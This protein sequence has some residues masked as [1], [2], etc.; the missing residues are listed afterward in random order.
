MLCAAP[1]HCR[2]GECAR[3]S[4]WGGG[5]CHRHHHPPAR[6]RSGALGELR[7]VPRG[8]WGV[9]PLN[10]S[11]ALSSATYTPR[12]RYAA[13]RTAPSTASG[14]ASHS[15]GTDA[16]RRAVAI[17][18]LLLAWSP[19]RAPSSLELN[20]PIRSASTAPHR[21]SAKSEGWR[22]TPR[23]RRRRRCEAY[24]YCTRTRLRGRGRDLAGAKRTWL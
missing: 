2:Q 24:M 23:R 21:C 7:N 16:T 19:R 18:T 20:D 3:L 13:H 4:M 6:D 15:G 14:T 11:K 1:S 22:L 10:F 17:G 9:A 12:E 5:V 8:V